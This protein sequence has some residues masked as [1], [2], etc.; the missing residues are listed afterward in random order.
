MV[1]RVSGFHYGVIVR[2]ACGNCALTMG[3]LCVNYGVI[4][5]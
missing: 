5:R 2:Y 1:V 3:L 4:V